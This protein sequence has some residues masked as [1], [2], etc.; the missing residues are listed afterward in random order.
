MTKPF[1]FPYNLPC[2]LTIGLCLIVLA[3][4]SSCAKQKREGGIT[5]GGQR[6]QD[7]STSSPGEVAYSPVP[8]AKG[9]VH[10]EAASISFGH[11]LAIQPLWSSVNGFSLLIDN[12]SDRERDLD[13]R[14]GETVLTERLSLEAQ[15]LRE[16]ATSPESIDPAREV[17]LWDREVG[18]SL[19]RLQLP[20]PPESRFPE[21][22]YRLYVGLNG[23]QH[24]HLYAEVMELPL[25]TPGKIQV[26]FRLHKDQRQLKVTKQA[27]GTPA[28]LMS[29]SPLMLNGEDGST[30]PTA[31][32]FLWKR[33]KNP[34][35]TSGEW[36]KIDA[37]LEIPEVDRARLVAIAV[38]TGD[39]RPWMVGVWVEPPLGDGGE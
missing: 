2:K 34:G 4:G 23:I 8:P 20:L 33:A 16:F 38:Q 19:G 7:P 22:R 31:D 26:R 36:S 12:F 27:L 32:G 17:L 10:G 14:Q 37:T 1:Q 18:E 25:R 35:G 21:W 11:L 3:L 5:S 30:Q 29:A 15:R 39:E 9:G 28:Q 6:N 13:L 24:P